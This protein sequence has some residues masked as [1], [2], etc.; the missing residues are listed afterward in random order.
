MRHD[1]LTRL[2]DDARNV[3]VEEELAYREQLPD[4]IRVV[5]ERLR[6]TIVRVEA[7]LSASTAHLLS[8]NGIRAGLTELRQHLERLLAAARTLSMNRGSPPI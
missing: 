8:A 6:E 3:L 1:Q 2:L 7:T 5:A 4:H